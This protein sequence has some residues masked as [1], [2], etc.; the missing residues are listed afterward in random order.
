MN[1]KKV[2]RQMGDKWVCHRSNHVSRLAVPI[3]D[4]VGTDIR[5]TFA[6]IQADRASGNSATV[7]KIRKGASK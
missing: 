5:T 6:R 3:K 2:I 1:V 4:S 7:T